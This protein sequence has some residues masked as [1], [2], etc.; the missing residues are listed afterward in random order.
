MKRN[1]ARGLYHVLDVFARPMTQLATSH[2][3]FD[4]YESDKALFLDLGCGR[5]EGA[6]E[7]QTH[8][9][10]QLV[11]I[12]IDTDALGKAKTRCPHAWYVRGNIECLPFKDA[13]FDATFSSSVLQYVHWRTVV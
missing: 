10:I 5:G 6:S 9:K 8:G 4:L 7:W 11:G 2:F 12:D 1:W 13:A 3:G